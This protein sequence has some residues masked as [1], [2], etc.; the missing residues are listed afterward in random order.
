[1]ILFCNKN[2]DYTEWKT[3]ALKR[4]PLL[5]LPQPPLLPTLRLDYYNNNNNSNS[6]VT[7]HNCCA[8]N[9]AVRID[10]ANWSFLRFSSRPTFFVSLLHHHVKRVVTVT[11]DSPQNR[12]KPNR[13][14]SLSLPERLEKERLEVPQLNKHATVNSA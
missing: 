5:T 6:A 4:L 11:T 3:V 2:S 10:R 14:F 12:T 13:F 1:M 8:Y 9:I 7:R